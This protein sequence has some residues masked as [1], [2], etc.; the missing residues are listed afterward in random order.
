[1]KAAVANKHL[2]GGTSSCEDNYSRGN[3][4]PRFVEI[5]LAKAGEIEEKDK[6]FVHG[7]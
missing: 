7:G 4:K 5:A 2:G 6:K 3:G 1:V